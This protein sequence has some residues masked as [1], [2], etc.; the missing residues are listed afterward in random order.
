M[1]ELCTCCYSSVQP[2]A[3][4]CLLLSGSLKVGPKKGRALREA[5]TAAVAKSMT[6]P[7]NQAKGPYSTLVS[8]CWP[9]SDK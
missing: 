9:T 7:S 6:P 8:A 4:V 2:L 3:V 5:T 1:P